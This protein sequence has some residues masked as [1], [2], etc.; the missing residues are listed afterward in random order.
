MEAGAS[1]AASSTRKTIAPV[2]HTLVLLTVFAALA[3]LG[4]LAQP[5]APVHARPASMQPRLIP[6][7]LEAIVFEW[8]TLAWVWFGVHLRGV[9]VSELIGGRWL[10]PKSIL[11]DVSLGLT[12]WAI[13]VGITK[14][15]ALFFGHSPDSIPFPANLVESVLAICVAVSAG[16]CEEIV[17][18]GYLQRQF[19]GITGSLVVSVVLQAIVFG[20]PH[21]YQGL[22]VGIMS[23]LYG[24]AFGV[25]AFWRRSLRPG[26]IAHV[27]SDIAARLL[28]V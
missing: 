14:A 8:A 11:V 2:W 27:W 17:F 10:N 3:V 7:Q 23:G 12:L 18:R 25:L 19:Y 13:W 28:R 9:R 22:R 15:V 6:L 24:V 4:A 1:P 20:V 21:V 5:S 16:V 26:I